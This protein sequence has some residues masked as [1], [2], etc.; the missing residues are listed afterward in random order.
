MNSE[1]FLRDTYTVAF[2]ACIFGLVTALY[3]VMRGDRR[4]ERM[5]EPYHRAPTVDQ[6][7]P[8]MISG[9]FVRENTPEEL[10]QYKAMN[11]LA[12]YF[13][14]TEFNPRWQFKPLGIYVDLKMYCYMIGAAILQINVCAALL[15]N[16]K[17][18]NGHATVAML[19][20]TACLTLFCVEYMYNEDVHTY[21]YDL[22][23]ERMGF[24][25]IWGCFCFYPFFYCI[26]VW[27]VLHSTSASD[28]S[29]VTAIAICL[30]YVMGWVFTRGANLQ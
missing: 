25:I 23:A 24:K 9:E 16:A 15:E 14:G 12:K 11:P 2:A 19:T 20:Y 8:K 6:Y 27:S 5:L 10:K 22:F 1:M 29:P 18:N 7:K 21:T 30:L 13:F 26:G 4:E 17:E 3:F 28:I